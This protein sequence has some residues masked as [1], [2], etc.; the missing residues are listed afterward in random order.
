V[1][2]DR[3]S[4]IGSPPLE[5]YSSFVLVKPVDH[6][7]QPQISKLARAEGHTQIAGNADRDN[8]DN[9]NRAA[10]KS[11]VVHIVQL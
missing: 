6:L 8:L 5:K 1:V 10:S 11:E 9:F 2:Y 3:P 7:G 4:V